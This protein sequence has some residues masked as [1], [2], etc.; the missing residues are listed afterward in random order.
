VVPP[1]R[2][3]QH[4]PAL[5]VTTRID[6]GL[7]PVTSM[8]RDDG[9]LMPGLASAVSTL[10][11][12]PGSAELA[13]LPGKVLSQVGLSGETVSR[14][15]LDPGSFDHAAL[16]AEWGR[17]DVTVT[18]DPSDR[19]TRI[20]GAVTRLAFGT[21]DGTLELGQLGLRADSAIDGGR[22][23]VRM[24]MSADD[25]AV[26]DLGDVDLVLEA[27]VERLDA[28]LA[29][30]LART[31]SEQLAPRAG[32]A[33]SAGLSPR[34][35]P[36]LRQL[37]AAGAGIRVERFDL[38]VPQGTVTSSARF[39]LPENDRAAF[40]WPALLLALTASV[41]LRL[42]AGLVDQAQAA[43][44]QVRSLVG[45][46]FLK[47][48]GTFYTLEADYAQGLLTVNGAPLPVPLPGREP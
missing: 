5:I 4:T 47:K 30:M 38:T 2:G 10:Q 45:L 46:G 23:N 31:W 22:L 12:D 13:D 24:A 16:Q 41:D 40:S 35:E 14:F 6:H 28:P 8:A 48:E 7:V 42:P 39:D 37:L 11:F 20:E 32:D 17:A 29:A 15:L 43:D 3:R 9:S 18:T 44:P 26:P 34:L 1:A 33:A 36:V 27:A 21:R 19:S 25:I